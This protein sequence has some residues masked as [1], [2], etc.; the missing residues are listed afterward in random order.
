MRVKGGASLLL[1]AALVVFVLPATGDSQS[2]APGTLQGRVV[3]DLEEEPVASAE[4]VVA[5]PGGSVVASAASGDDG[6]F[7]ITGIPQGSYIYGV[8]REGFDELTGSVVVPGGAIRDMGDLVLHADPGGKGQSAASPATSWIGSAL[9]AG[10][11]LLAALVFVARHSK[12]L[13]TLSGR[14]TRETPVR[15]GIPPRTLAGKHVTGARRVAALRRERLARG[16]AK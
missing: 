7:E 13:M 2:A 14:A 9:V 8:S 10:F 5:V 3:S 6:R 12:R 1:V 15:A 4:I 11:I 16:Q